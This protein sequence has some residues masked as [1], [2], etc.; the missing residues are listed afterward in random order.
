VAA[1][2]RLGLAPTRFEVGGRR[3]PGRHRQG[4]GGDLGAGER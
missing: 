3:R 2:A 4:D 1:L